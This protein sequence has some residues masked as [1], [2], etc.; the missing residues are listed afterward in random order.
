M[1]LKGTGSVVIG[2]NTEG[3]RNLRRFAIPQNPM[4]DHQLMK[5]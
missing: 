2:Y 3:P 5:A 1:L 4:K